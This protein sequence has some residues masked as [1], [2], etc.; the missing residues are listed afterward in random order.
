MIELLNIWELQSA[1]VLAEK[2]KS[3]ILLI[4]YIV[5]YLTTKRSCF[6]VAFIFDE[7]TS[8]ASIFD[9]LNN[10]DYALMPAFIYAV[11]LRRLFV[12]DFK[13]KTKIACGIMI[14]FYIWNCLDVI[15]NKQINTHLYEFYIYYVMVIH[16]YII[17]T[18]VE[19]R[20]IKRSFFD[21]IN[22]FSRLLCGGYFIATLRYNRTT[23]SKQKTN[24]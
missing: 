23:Y 24:L 20:R 7:F 8:T 10:I 18:A 16:F 3:N 5:V 15:Y 13:L 1:S 21:I 17:F 14:L 9:F 4:S 19:W 12:I 22:S 6:L 11:L 2:L